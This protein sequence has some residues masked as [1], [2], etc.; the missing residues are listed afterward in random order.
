MQV[1]PRVP[2]I[3]FIFIPSFYRLSSIQR[4]RVCEL[5]PNANRLPALVLSSLLGYPVLLSPSVHLHP[6]T[7][8]RDTI[9]PIA[10]TVHLQRQ[11]HLF[12]PDIY[13]GA[14]AE[15]ETDSRPFQISRTLTSTCMRPSSGCHSCQLPYYTKFRNNFTSTAKH[16]ISQLTYIV[17]T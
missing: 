15:S 11:N 13:R 4:Q 8:Q 7:E 14:V 12:Q 10:P 3:I 1:H 2:S 16:E 9:T 17:C 6:Y 5:V